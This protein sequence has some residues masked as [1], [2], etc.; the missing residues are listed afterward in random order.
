MPENKEILKS[1]LQDVI[2]DRQEDATAKM[3]DYFI[4]KSQEVASLKTPPVE[5]T[6]EQEQY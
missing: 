5:Q 1:M 3:H 4:A 2:N 6:A